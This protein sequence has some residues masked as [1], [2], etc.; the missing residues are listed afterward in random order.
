MYQNWDSFLTDPYILGIAM[1][2]L[3][4]YNRE[5]ASQGQMIESLED[6]SFRQQLE[7]ANP[8]LASLYEGKTK[9]ELQ[10]NVHIL[11]IAV[12]VASTLKFLAA[13]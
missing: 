4:G 8:Q 2:F 10:E 1:L 7:E 12:G 3:D 9:D 6:D 5:K 11:A 13:K